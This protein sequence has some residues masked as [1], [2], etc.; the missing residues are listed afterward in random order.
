[1]ET[2]VVSPSGALSPGLLTASA[3]VVGLYLGYAGGVLVAVGHMLFELPYV[4]LIAYFLGKLRSL[5]SKLE[6]P[7]ALLV[8][9]FTVYFALGLIRDALS[10]SKQVVGVEGVSRVFDP[11]SPFLAVV[12][13]VFYT[14]FNPYFLLWWLTVGLPLVRDAGLLGVRGLAAMYLSHVWLDYA[15]LGMLAGLGGLA[16]LTASY[17]RVILL[18]LTAMLLGFA[19]FVVYKAFTASGAREVNSQSFSSNAQG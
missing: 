18:G 9:G 3:I 19:L 1:M 2:L 10:L 8:L 5:I 13:G 11:R 6:K 15:W 16:S 4:L 17:Y 12:T 14:G 7:M